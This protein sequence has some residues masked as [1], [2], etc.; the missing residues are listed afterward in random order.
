[1]EK[2]DTGIPHSA[3]DYL[4]VSSED[5]TEILYN[6]IL[7]RRFATVDAKA[8]DFIEWLENSKDYFFGVNAQSTYFQWVEIIW[9][10]F[11]KWGEYWREYNDF[12]AASGPQSVTLE[13]L[14]CIQSE[15]SAQTGSGRIA[16]ITIQ[17]ARNYFAESSCM[18]MAETK[19][20]IY[21]K[22]S[23]DILKIN[24]ATVRIDNRKRFMQ[25]QRDKYEG[26]MEVM[27]ANVGYL[28][29]IWKKWP[30]KTKDAHY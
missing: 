8:K 14:A 30:S 24:K 9:A 15:L 29:R 4:C 20:S 11:G 19:L 10:K 26:L 5:N 27:R 12:C 23:Y 6:I 13:T 17:N 1:M 2:N 7:D 16:Q 18:L 25:N 3:T 21:A 28:E 22:V